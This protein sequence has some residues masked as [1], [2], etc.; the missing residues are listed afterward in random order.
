MSF[1]DMVK[2]VRGRNNGIIKGRYNTKYRHFTYHGSPE[3]KSQ[4][5]E[6]IKNSD[7]FEVYSTVY[8]FLNALENMG[9]CIHE[10]SRWYLIPTDM[11]MEY[12]ISYKIRMY[13]NSLLTDVDINEKTYIPIS[14]IVS[15]VISEDWGFS[16][17]GY[18]DVEIDEEYFNDTGDILYTVTV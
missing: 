14:Q 11:A 8:Y 10:G 5:E 7:E 1:N 13:D 17:Y 3:Y 18:A 15:G 16:V 6:Q 4:I 12:S 9:G 2:F